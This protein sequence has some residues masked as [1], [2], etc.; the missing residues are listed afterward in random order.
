MKKLFFGNIPHTSSEDELKE[1]VESR[2]F[3]VESAE[4]IRDRST[5]HSRGFAFVELKQEGDVEGAIKALNGQVMGERVLTVNH[6][7][8]FTARPM[9]DASRAS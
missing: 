9:R 4:I 7:V 5:H 6:A 3:Q 1:W 8:P 2:G